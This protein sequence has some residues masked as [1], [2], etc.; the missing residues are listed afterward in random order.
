MNYVHTQQM[1]LEKGIILRIFHIMQW[2]FSEW[3][4]Y[5]LELG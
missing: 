3:T 5:L 2:M 4:I 1:Y